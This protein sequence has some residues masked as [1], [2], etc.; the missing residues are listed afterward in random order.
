MAETYS[1]Y[2]DRIRKGLST[3]CGGANA[4][5][6]FAEAR[7]HLAESIDELVARGMTRDA[8]EGTAMER[9]GDADAICAWYASVHRLPSVWRASRWPLLIL[10]VFVL[11]RHYRL[12][13]FHTH[14]GAFD[15]LSLSP[16]ITLNVL[17]LLLAVACY[18]SKRFTSGVM[19]AALMAVSLI[20]IASLSAF[21]VR[22]PGD[23]GYTYV[24]RASVK[25]ELVN[26]GIR[27]PEAKRMVQ[28]MLDGENVFAS[29]T[30]SEGA[31]SLHVAEGYLTP[32]YFEQLNPRTRAYINGRETTGIFPRYELARQ[33]WVGQP[34]NPGE[35]EPFYVT[36][37][38][39]QVAREE[40][41]LT[42]LP[43]LAAQPWTTNFRFFAAN[44]AWEVTFF[45]G[46]ALLADLLGGGLRLAVQRLKRPR[47]PLTA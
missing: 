29:K 27:L 13:V 37:A 32:I 8:A 18:R 1:D 20:Q 25:G 23:R 39:N 19:L 35:T 7:A 3:G 36:E 46:F 47:G 40:R 4:G 44:A 33:F 14:W 11:V 10:A 45:I 31:E 28:I 34:S 12:D 17:L 22:E 24:S 43:G 38:R 6:I 26:A 42:E 5:V 21:A 41:I 2:L 16:V 15:S 30:P 9:F